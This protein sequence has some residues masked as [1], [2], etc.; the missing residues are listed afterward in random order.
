MS[1]RDRPQ[2]CITLEYD[3]TLSETT[4]A[5]QL[6]DSFTAV[7]LLPDPTSRIRRLWHCNHDATMIDLLN[8]KSDERQQE[9][10][11]WFAR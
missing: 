2:C 4:A 7:T 10:G 8:S 5:E 11:E 9:F 1:L 3:H 6:A